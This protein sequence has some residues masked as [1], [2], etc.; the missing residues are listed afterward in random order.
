MNGSDINLFYSTPACYLKSLHDAGIKWPTKT[1]DFLP[2]AS[3]IHT[4]WTGYYT[5]RP[6][7]KRYERVSNH[8]LQI[9]KQLTYVNNTPQ[10]LSRLSCLREVMGVMQ[11]HDAVTGTEK[12]KVAYDYE[13]QLSV[14]ISECDKNT[15][16]V[17]NLFATKES[18]KKLEFK[19]CDLLNISSCDVSEKSDQF[20]L[21]LYNPLGHSNSDYVRVPV[22]GTNY[23]V[24]DPKGLY[25]TLKRKSLGH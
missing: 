11:H 12:Q 3:D 16:E 2:Y 7:L 19:T 24:F 10:F 25:F 17:L 5:S 20:V 14:A 4:Y 6:T 1:D 9:C 8:F 13:R 22:I 15:R 23:E 18:S 21:T